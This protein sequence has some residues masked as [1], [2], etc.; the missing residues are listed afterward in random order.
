MCRPMW[1]DGMVYPS[2]HYKRMGGSEEEKKKQKKKK[3][4]KKPLLC[5]YVQATIPT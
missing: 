4:S 5:V 3:K 2:C 1:V